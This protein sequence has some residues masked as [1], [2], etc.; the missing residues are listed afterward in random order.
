[1]KDGTI[2]AYANDKELARFKSLNFTYEKL[3]NPSLDLKSA[4]KMKTFSR[5]GDAIQWDASAYEEYV[6]IMM[7]FEKN[8]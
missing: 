4:P 7:D 1:L 5:F 3:L 2:F 6:R 8:S